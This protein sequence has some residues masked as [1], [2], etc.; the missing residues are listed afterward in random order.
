MF[1]VDS[2]GIRKQLKWA[3]AHTHFFIVYIEQLTFKIIT[4]CYKDDHVS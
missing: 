4:K 1:K 3:G 2:A